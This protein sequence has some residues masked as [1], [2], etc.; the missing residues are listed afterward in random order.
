[1]DSQDRPKLAHGSTGG[2]VALAS[3]I[4]RL[5]ASLAV[6][7]PRDPMELERWVGIDPLTFA[8]PLN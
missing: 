1:M 5:Y 6:W 8:K 3:L 7:V 2:R 4:G